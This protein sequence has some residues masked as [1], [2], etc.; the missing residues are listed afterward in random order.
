MNEERLINLEIKFSHQEDFIEKLNQVVT[1]QQL[2][3]ES[4]EKAMIDLKSNINS[5][6]EV[7]ETRTLADDKPPHY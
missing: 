6:S 1:E 5:G 4:L 7:G 2:K 3:I